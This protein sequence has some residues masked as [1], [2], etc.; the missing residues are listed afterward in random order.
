MLENAN[1]EFV[2]G[3]KYSVLSVQSQLR[4]RNQDRLSKSCPVHGCG[5]EWATIHTSSQNH[6]VVHFRGTLS[7]I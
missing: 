5:Q 2:L 3:G 4:P 7:H 1:V 6:H